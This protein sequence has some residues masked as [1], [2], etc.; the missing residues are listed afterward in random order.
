MAHAPRQGNHLSRHEPGRFSG[1]TAPWNPAVHSGEAHPNFAPGNGP[2]RRLTG[3]RRRGTTLRGPGETS[4]SLQIEEVR[5]AP[6]AGGP[7]TPSLEF[8]KGR[9]KAMIDMGLRAEGERDG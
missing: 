3:P 4:T 2:F 8:S 9:R 1:S 7:V 6:G 5:P